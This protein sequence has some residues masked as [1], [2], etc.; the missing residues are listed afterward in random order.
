MWSGSV[1]GPKATPGQYRVELAIG[2]EIIGSETFDIKKDPR[3][4]VSEDDLKESLKFQLKVR[5]K[6]SAIHKGVNDLRAIRKQTN[7]YLK[8]VQD[9]VFKKELEKVSKPMLDSL[10]SVEN[11]LIQHEA[12]AFQDLLALPIRLNDQIAGLAAAASSADTRPTQ[13]TYEVYAT[14]SVLADF[15]L[16]KLKKI[17]LEQVPAFNQ[18]TESRKMPVLNIDKK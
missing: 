10:Q 18:L 8:S 9:T 1:V 16:E 4:S 5:D 3:L 12:K 17:L 6:V 14:L 13:Q 2:K 7:D 11:Q 15:Q